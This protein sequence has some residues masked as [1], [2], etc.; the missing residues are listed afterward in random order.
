MK[1][2]KHLWGLA[3]HIYVNWMNKQVHEGLSEFWV[4]RRQQLIQPLPRCS[5]FSSRSAPFTLRVK[6]TPR[7]TPHSESSCYIQPALP[8]CVGIGSGRGMMVFAALPRA[9][10]DFPAVGAHPEASREHTLIQ[11]PS[12][13][14]FQAFPPVRILLARPWRTLLPTTF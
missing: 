14:T 9:P 2:L 7:G 5:F 12:W 4:G 8:C 11:M 10:S 1:F 6:E 3:P 13:T